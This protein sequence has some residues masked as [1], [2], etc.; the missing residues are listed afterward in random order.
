[1]STN[2]Y[3]GKHNV[4]A[5]PVKRRKKWP[6]I[7]ALVAMLCCIVTG[8]TVAY[9]VSK[10]ASV[11]N[12]FQ[13]GQMSSQVIENFDG[14]TKSNV[15][16]KNTGDTSAYIRAQVVITWVSTTNN[17][18]VSAQTPDPGTDYTI[19]YGNSGWEQGKDGYWYYTS[20]VAKDGSTA[21][22][23]QECKLTGTAPEGYT[24]SV[25][26][27]ADAIQAEPTTAVEEAWSTGVSGVG[28]DY[29]LT[30]I[31]QGGAS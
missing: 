26:I 6:V 27:I 18:V 23:I 14:T 5:R 11:V 1:M 22:L 31:K 19:T 12:S 17:S 24:L 2:H 15:S 13:V 28:T 10:P 3:E 29:K 8:V 21:T 20:P 9:L 30:V 7:L 25:E 4:P 16:I